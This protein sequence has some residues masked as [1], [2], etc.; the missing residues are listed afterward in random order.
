MKTKGFLIAAI[1]SGSGKTTITCA[2]LEALKQRGVKLSAFKCGPDYIDPMF[3]KRVIGVESRNLDT[4]FVG[5]EKI[6][7]LYIQGRDEEE[8]SVIEGVMG[9]YDG[10]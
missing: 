4:F 2:I 10:L 5:P 1:K 8:I 9:L 3:H 7:D 6:R